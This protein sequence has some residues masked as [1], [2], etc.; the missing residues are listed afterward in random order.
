MYQPKLAHA[1]LFVRDLQRSVAFY[2]TYLNLRVTETVAERSAFLTGG[3]PHHELALT[4]K[5][6]NAPPPQ[7]GGVGLFH[8]AFDVAD[9]RSFAE[10]YQ[11][12]TEGNVQVSPVDHQIGW[13]MYFSDPTCLKSIATRDKSRTALY[14]GAARTVPSRPAKSW[15]SSIPKCARCQAQSG[16]CLTS[17]STWTPRQGAGVA[18]A[19]RRLASFVSQRGA[20]QNRLSAPGPAALQG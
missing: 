5:G 17:R 7:P 11:R 13:G 1:H 3:G 6:V 2:Q 8:L 4:A 19:R 12:L 18:A 14:C 15:P 20:H 16:E 10:A 9:K